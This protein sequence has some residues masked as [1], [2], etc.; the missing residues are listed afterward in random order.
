MKLAIIGS[1]SFRDYELIKS[2]LMRYSI[3]E[4]VSGGAKGADTLAEKFADEHKIKKTIF[5]PNYVKYGKKAPLIR[6][7]EIV[8]Y[9]DKVVAFWDGE[10]RGTKYTIDYAEKKG[11]KVDVIHCEEK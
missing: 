6:N 11:K 8:D 5:Q 3:E 2:V 10:S 1:R 7:R 9:S 4:I